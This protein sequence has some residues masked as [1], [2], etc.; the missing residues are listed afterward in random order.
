MHKT[1]EQRFWEKVGKKREDD[2][3]LWLGA[4]HHTGYNQFDVGGKKV[5]AHRYSWILSFGNIPNDINVLHSCD[6]P[7]CVNPK[8][9]FLG[10]QQDNVQDCKQKGRLNRAHGEKHGRAKLTDTIVL[11]I[12]LKLEKGWLQKDVAKLYHVSQAHISRIALDK[13]WNT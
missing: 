13:G 10:T 4:R 8:H 3:W 2:C 11:D 6:R 12:K 1:A 7:S 9:L 5:A